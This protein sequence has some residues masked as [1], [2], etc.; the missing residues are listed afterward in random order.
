[1]STPAPPYITQHTHPTADVCVSTS[2]QCLIYSVHQR[3]GNIKQD[4]LHFYV[5]CLYYII[6]TRTTSISLRSNGRLALFF[7]CVCFRSA[8]FK[9]LLFPFFAVCFYIYETTCSDE[10]RGF[11]SARGRDA[12]PWP[13]IRRTTSGR[14]VVAAAATAY[15]DSSSL[16]YRL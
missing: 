7:V 12:K 1:M 9:N 5:L 16:L 11:S 6:H 13:N 10:L 14:R 15:I 3:A 8:Q 2:F 4:A